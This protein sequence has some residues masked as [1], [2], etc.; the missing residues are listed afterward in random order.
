MWSASVSRNHGHQLALTADLAK[1]TGN[2][3]L[4]IDADLQDFPAAATIRTARRLCGQ[5]NRSRSDN[6]GSQPGIL[7]STLSYIFGLERHLIGRVPMPAGVSL[8][9]TYHESAT[10]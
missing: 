6:E 5:A 3:V 4:I 8:M 10:M 9:A 2:R 7:N 1:A